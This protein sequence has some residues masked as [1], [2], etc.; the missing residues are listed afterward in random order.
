[1]ILTN[2]ILFLIMNTIALCVYFLKICYSYGCFYKVKNKMVIDLPF[3]G[4]IL[5]VTTLLTDF[6]KGL[7][8]LISFKNAWIYFFIASIVSFIIMGLKKKENI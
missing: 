7:S 6:P 8:M 3:E 5:P 2:T 1:M 4:I